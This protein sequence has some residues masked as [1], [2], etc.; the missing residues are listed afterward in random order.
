MTGLCGVRPGGGYCFAGRRNLVGL[1]LINADTLAGS[2]FVVSPLDETLACL[3]ALY[4]DTPAHPGE[5]DWL[6]A[7][8]EA[9]RHRLA[10]DPLTA[11]LVRAAL[12]RTWLA[13][14]LTAPPLG[15]SFTEG[16]ARIRATPASDVHA[17]LAVSLG[18]PVPADLLSR[19]DLAARTADLLQWVWTET[20]RPY[21]QRRRR[22]LEAD[23][24]SRT[25]QLSQ[26]GWAA[27]LDDMRRGMR[28]LGDGRLQINAYDY[29]PQEIADAQLMFIP[30]T[31][32]RGWVSWDGLNR[33]AVI[34]PCSGVLAEPA[35]TPTPEALARLLGPARAGVLTLLGTPLSTTQL[36]A[37][38]DQ[39]LGSVGRHLKV[40]LDAGLIHHRRA[41]RSVLYYRTPTGDAL[42]NAQ[43]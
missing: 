26:G 14:Y 38:T 10:V 24:V 18:H 15:E 33:Y 39:G 2:R 29:P 41:G 43:G 7:H 1:W 13:D 28:W 17:D 20:V 35:S 36:V 23:I 42:I 31:L 22:L 19:T 32:G 21:W 40:L 25:R 3:I 8:R 37:L 27:A 30:V 6:A 11:R 12:G 34:Y 5:R 16:L 4:R 9:Y